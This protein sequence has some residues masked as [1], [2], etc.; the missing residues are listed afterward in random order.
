MNSTVNVTAIILAGGIGLRMGGGKP[1]QFLEIEGKPIFIHSIETFEKHPLIDRIILVINGK[2]R[3]EFN[4]LL[5]P[6]SFKKL[7]AIVEGGAERSDSTRNALA[8]ISHCSKMKLLIHDA[9]RPYVSHQII[10]DVVHKLERYKA[11]NVGIPATDTVFIANQR[12]EIQEIPSRSSVFLA[13]T[14]QGFL[15]ET[16]LEA[17]YLAS[18]DPNFKVTDDCG[19]VHHY[20]PHIPIAIVEGGRENIKI[21]FPSD[22]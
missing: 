14:P 7:S 13:Q 2:F 20:L 6:Y 22:L 4:Q 5:S 1:K 21:T 10:S 9:V 17:Y 19:V 8:V 15:G 12:G 3:S 11:V 18:K 16:I